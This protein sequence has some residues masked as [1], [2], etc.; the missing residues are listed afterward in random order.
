MKAK[1]TEGILKEW[2]NQPTPELHSLIEISF[3][4]GI[5]EVREK[6]GQ[7]ITD[8]IDLDYWANANGYVKRDIPALNRIAKGEEK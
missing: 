6:I 1:D 7:A 8:I 3:K 5:K 2:I 4:A